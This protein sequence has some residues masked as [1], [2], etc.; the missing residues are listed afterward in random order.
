M[1]AIDGTL[2][3]LEA[4]RVEAEVGADVRQPGRERARAQRKRS[5]RPE[6]RLVGEIDDELG[7]AEVRRA[8]ARRSPSPPRSFSVPPTRI[9]PDHVVRQLGE[10]VAHDVRVVLPVDRARPPLTRVVT[11][12]SI[13]PCTS[14][15]RACRV[16]LNDALLTVKRVAPPAATCVPDTSDDVVTGPRVTTEAAALDSVR[17]LTT[18]RFSSFQA[19]GTCLCP[20]KHEEH[21]GALQALDRVARVVDD[22]ALATRPPGSAAGVVSTKT[23]KSDGSRRELAP[24]SQP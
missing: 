12:R 20:D 7:V 6:H 2:E 9:A 19:Y 22:V 15:T 3:R 16:E 8:A 24:R 21:A 11:S 1:T 17:C 14:R 5:R 23:R 18:N 13:G 10:R 4:R